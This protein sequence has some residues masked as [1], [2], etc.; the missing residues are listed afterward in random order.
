MKKNLL[1]FIIFG[2]VILAFVFGFIFLAG[3]A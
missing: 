2:A 3:L 1:T